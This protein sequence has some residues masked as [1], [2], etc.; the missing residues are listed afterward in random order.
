VFDF[1]KAT[2]EEDVSGGEL[3]QLQ[4]CI[5]AIMLCLSTMTRKKREG[6]L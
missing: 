2:S 4:A 1:R 3:K 5:Y 6:K